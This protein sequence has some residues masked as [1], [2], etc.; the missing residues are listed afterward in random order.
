MGDVRVTRIFTGDDGQSHFEELDVPLHG[1]TYGELSDLVPTA[2]VM[3]RSTPPDGLLGFHTAP[4][5]QFVV[6]LLG[7]VE[8][9]CGDGTIRRFA[10]GD[11]MLADDTTGQGHISR[12]VGGIRKSLFLPLPDDFDV[13]VWRV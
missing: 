2:G 12:E 7:A 10:D 11:I 13:S 9:E 1:A 3:F 8:V 4:R 5:R 6:T